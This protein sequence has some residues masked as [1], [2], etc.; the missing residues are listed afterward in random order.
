MTG[1]QIYYA[2]EISRFV[3]QNSD[4]PVVW[5]GVHPCLL[6]LQTL[7]NEN[8]D[9]I[10]HGE[11]EITFHS[12]LKALE[13]GKPLKSVDGIWYKERGKPKKTEPR[14]FIKDLDIL[15]EKPYEL[16]NLN[17]Y[18][19]FSFGDERSITL[20]TSRGCPFRCGFC[21]NTV[22]N[23]RMWRGY[24]SK[25]SLEKIR[26]ITE[27]LGI[28]GIYIQ[29]DNFVANLKRYE[30]ILDGIS[31]EK[32]DMIWGLLGARADSLERM[33]PDLLKKTRRAGCRHIDVGVE[34]GSER[35]LK[36][37]QKDITVPRVLAVNN[38]LADFD[39][40]VKY[41]F[42]AGFP[43][44]TEAETRETVNL[45]MR[46]AED[47]KNAFTPLYIYTPY[48]GTPLYN[49]ALE[50][51]FKPPQTLEGWSKF[52]F[53]DWYL[54]YPSWLDKKRIKILD[55]LSFTALF[56]NKNIKHKIKKKWMRT[57]FE[58][59]NPIAK[60][61]FRNNFYHLPLERMIEKKL[62]KTPDID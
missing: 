53:L 57:L 14:D 32:I 15:P 25:R 6:P 27:E 59:Y 21:Y 18:Y 7:E 41:T 9:I 58:L 43:T 23:K 17:D 20:E 56:A 29:D 45:A 50:N 37:I 22:F 31:K 40:K 19:G 16:I 30:E 46:L 5:G 39:F 61:R 4:V 47:N 28:K 52:T 36:L 60:F 51:G 38:K 8:I 33:S 24:S 34:S 10:I 12:L 54:N 3:K 2:L 35:I 62:M 42:I 13:K 44:E 1:A 11:G 26:F 49:L 48:P 55:N